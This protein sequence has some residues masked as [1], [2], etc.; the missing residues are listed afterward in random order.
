MITVMNI[1]KAADTITKLTQMGD[2]TLFEPAGDTPGKEAS[3]GGKYQSLSLAECITNVQTPFGAKPILKTMVTTA[4]ERNCN[5]CV[6]RAGRGKTRR[7]TITPDALAAAFDQLQRAKLA[8]GMFLSSG[9][10]K[11][12]AAAQDK[13]IATG[14][15][16]RQKYHYRG[17]LHLKIMPGAEYDQIHRLM[18]LADRVSV[19]L[20][21]PTE[22]RLQALAPKK[23][24]SN[25]LLIQL[26]RAHE[27]KQQDPSIRASLVTQ[28]VVGAVGDTDLELLSLGDRLYNRLGLK[29][30]YFS[31]FGPVID[32]PFENLAPTAP[33][34]EFRLYQASFLLRDYAWEL[35]DL[36]FVE[37]E[38]L[39]TD[40]DPKLA[41]AEV[42]LRN[43][44]IDVMK[45]DRTA[46]MRLPGVGPKG[47]DAI[48]K[49]R[50]ERALRDL[51]QLGKLGIRTPDQLAPYVLFDG[52][53]PSQQL[54]LF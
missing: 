34:R 30:T 47:A 12:G 20:E 41:W 40:I 6:F 19:N 32:T 18:Q 16:I 31:A 51:G 14:E 48:L 35:E 38:N 22:A 39:R 52:K 45:A 49:A 17:F 42:N 11:G 2:A 21:G 24:F 9:I 46:L 15:I 50:A 54:S 4:C 37:G 27:I 53:Q 28:F 26:Q 10:I 25:E 13:I 7:V 23:N 36:P 44:P 29:R 33:I 5:Y 3:G 1:H 8:D 43:K